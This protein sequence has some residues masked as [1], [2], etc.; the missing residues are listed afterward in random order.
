MSDSNK[1]LVTI[2]M[3]VHGIL[4][5]YIAVHN[6]LFK[7][8][9]RRLITLPLIFKPIDF[10]Q[11]HSQSNELIQELEANKSHLTELKPQTAPSELANTLGEFCSALID[12]ISLLREIAYQLDLRSKKVG[13]YS[14]HRHKELLDLYYQSIERYRT[15]GVK[16]NEQFQEV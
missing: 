14:Y 2:A 16:L 11:L 13:D 1:Q 4:D 7:S 8:P 5:R 6:R 9:L 15:I 10:K 12:T 3:G